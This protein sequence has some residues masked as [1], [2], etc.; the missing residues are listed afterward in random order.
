[1]HKTF[2]YPEAEGVCDNLS[3]QQADNVF[4]DSW[5]LACVFVCHL[6][7]DEH[8]RI[9]CAQFFVGEVYIIQRVRVVTQRFNDT[10]D[11]Y[12]EPVFRAAV[13]MQT[14]VSWEVFCCC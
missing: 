8:V 13:I 11:K 14:H 10:C 3:V 9:L 7:M 2:V 1:M 5:V 12:F 4:V 6:Y